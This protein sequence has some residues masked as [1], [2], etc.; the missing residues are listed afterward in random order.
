MLL[1]NL[2]FFDQAML[3]F[4]HGGASVEGAYKLAREAT[5]KRNE[6]HEKERPV[7]PVLPS[8]YVYIADF[9][10]KAM[11]ELQAEGI[12]SIVK[13]EGRSGF[14]ILPDPDAPTP[15]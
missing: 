9:Q 1:S 15:V 3:A 10:D 6:H 14:Y 2:E 13:V 8:G 12:G 4:I 7:K 11:A 5:V